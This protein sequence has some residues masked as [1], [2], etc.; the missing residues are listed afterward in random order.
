MPFWIVTGAN[1]GL[2]LEFVTQ[3]TTDPSN[4]VI[5]TVRSLSNDISALKSLQ[6]PSLHILECD[7][8]SQESIKTFAENVS[9]T[10]G[11]EKQ[12]DFLLNNAGINTTPEQTSETMTPDSLTN[13]I[14]VNVMGPATM[15]QVLTPHLQKGSVVMNMSSGLGS[16]S[17]NASKE[18]VEATIYCISKAALNMLTVHQAGQWEARGVKFLAVDPGWVKTDMGGPMAM[19]EKEESIAGMLKVLRSKDTKSG[20]YL[21]YNGSKREW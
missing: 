17:Y 3:L 16:M 14:N 2:G 18:T 9:K 7:T 11:A 10:F 13:H 5:A 19:L 1:R 15:V 20:E 8:S 4:T 21:E 6:S 12:V